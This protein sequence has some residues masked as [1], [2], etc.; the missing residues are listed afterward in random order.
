MSSEGAGGGAEAGGARGAGG[1]R[2]GGGHR[3]RGDAGRGSSVQPSASARRGPGRERGEGMT[4]DSRRTRIA[5]RRDAN[6]NGANPACTSDQVAARTTEARLR[7]PPGHGHPCDDTSDRVGGHRG[8][9]GGPAP[10]G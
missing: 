10:P 3:G 6:R 2:R 7:G 1:S 4:T 8:G 5:G 9:E